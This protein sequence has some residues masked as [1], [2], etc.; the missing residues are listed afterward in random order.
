MNQPTTLF[1]HGGPGLSAIV[2][3]ELYGIT[4]KIGITSNRPQCQ[5]RQLSSSASQQEAR[6]SRASFSDQR[7][8]KLNVA[9]SSKPRHRL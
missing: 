5:I 4:C 9:L 7:R 6:P 1:L 2:E 8:R 3:R